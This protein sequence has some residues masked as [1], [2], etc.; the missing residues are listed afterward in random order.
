[1][2]RKTDFTPKHSA[3]L[4]FALLYS[5]PS[6]NGCAAVCVGRFNCFVCIDDQ[7]TPLAHKNPTHFGA[8]RKLKTAAVGNAELDEVAPTYRELLEG[9][10][11]S[12]VQGCV[13]GVDLGGKEVTVEG[14]VSDDLDGFMISD[15]AGQG[16]WNH[17][18]CVCRRRRSR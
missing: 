17:F 6:L 1:M 12:F 15:H 5:V 11:V 8:T 13:S 7:P 4:P 16:A 3:L 18:H 9:S 10:D 14:A 2:R